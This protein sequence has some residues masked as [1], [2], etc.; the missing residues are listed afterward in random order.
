MSNFNLEALKA[1]TLTPE[2]LAEMA[3]EYALPP[4]GE[5]AAVVDGNEL[6]ELKYTDKKTGLEVVKPKL[7]IKWSI[8]DA[9]VLETLGRDKVIVMQ[10]II[11]NVDDN[12]V[13]DVMNNL[14]LANLGRNVWPGD[15]LSLYDN[16]FCGRYANVLIRHVTDKQKEG[17]SPEDCKTRAKVTRVKPFTG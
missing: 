7:T 10:D 16:G 2:T 5:V 8:Q 17:Q 12:N 4:E 9:A 15:E 11:I 13:P 3:T 6:G 1:M 14:E